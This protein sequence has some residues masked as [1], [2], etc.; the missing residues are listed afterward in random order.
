[1]PSLDHFAAASTLQTYEKAVEGF[2][3][4]HYPSFDQLKACGG[5]RE[6]HQPRFDVLI[7][8]AVVALCGADLTHRR[9]PCDQGSRCA[10]ALLPA[11]GCFAIEQ[12]RKAPK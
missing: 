1:M 4:L 2:A 9:L 6:K 10:E 3:K 12:R 11:C 5:S 8:A 7:E